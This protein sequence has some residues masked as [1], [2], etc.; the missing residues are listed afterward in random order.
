MCNLGDAIERKGITEGVGLGKF[1]LA[2]KY[3]RNGR[4]TA[5]EA[6]SDLNMPLSQF[7]DKIKEGNGQCMM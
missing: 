7:L 2:S 6:A 3:Y 5:E 4:I 1:E